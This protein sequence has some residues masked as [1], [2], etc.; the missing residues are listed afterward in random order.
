MSSKPQRSVRVSEIIWNKVKA[1][2]AAEG[3]TACEVIND[4]LKDYIK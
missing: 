3:K 2:A 4:Y 1:K